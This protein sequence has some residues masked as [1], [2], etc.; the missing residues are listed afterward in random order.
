MASKVRLAVVVA[1]SYTVV[2]VPLTLSEACRR[3]FVDEVDRK[4]V[5][6]LRES[7][8]CAASAAGL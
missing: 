4:E 2:S 3:L 7:H 1:S 6:K 5:K 8:H